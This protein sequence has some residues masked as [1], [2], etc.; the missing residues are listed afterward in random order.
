MTP[1][2]Y[3]YIRF[4]TPEQ[5]KG[6]S[7]RRQLK[8]SEEYAAEKG[9]VLDDRLSLRDLGLSA[10]HGHHR[11]KGALGLFLAQVEE[12]KIPKGSMLIVESLDRLSREEVLDALGQFTSIIKAGVTV[13]TLIDRMEYSQK[14]VNANIGQL[15]ISITIIE[16]R[17]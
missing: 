13:V 16:P 6:D 11:S 14:S 10:F 3:S 12:G 8:M 1:K 7:L 4:S 9:L 15:I 17:P 2:C 5:L